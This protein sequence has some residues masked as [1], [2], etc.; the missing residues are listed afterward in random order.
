[1]V[2]GPL[3]DQEGLFAAVS[4]HGTSCKAYPYNCIDH[5]QLERYLGFGLVF[6]IIPILLLKSHQN[7]MEEA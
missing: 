1:M 3:F 6:L 7:V 2:F 4:D 5:F